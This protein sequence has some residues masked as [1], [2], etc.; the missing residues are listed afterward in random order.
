M[1]R[2]QSLKWMFGLSALPLASGGFARAGEGAGS[3]LPKSKSEWASL[4]P[5]PAYRVL[6]EEDAERAD[7]LPEPRT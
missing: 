5:P 7:T 3:P 2:R 6:F 1:D 4:L